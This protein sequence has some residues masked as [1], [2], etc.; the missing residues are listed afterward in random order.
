MDKGEGKVYKSPLEKHILCPR[1]IAWIVHGL[2]EPVTRVQIPAGA[3]A[4]AGLLSLLGFTCGALGLELQL[5][6]SE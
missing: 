1:S 5:V 3:L 6:C 2:A 4:P